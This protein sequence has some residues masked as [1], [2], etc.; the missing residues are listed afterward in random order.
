MGGAALPQ[1][2]G[3]SKDVGRPVIRLDI[4]QMATSIAAPA[5]GAVAGLL[6][7]AVLILLSGANPLV[8]YK[9]LALG[10]LGGP[11]QLTDTIL[12]ATPLLIMGLGLMVAFRCRAWNIGGAGQFYIGALC[13]VIVG[14]TF[15]NSW[16]AYLL[17]PAML[18]AGAAGGALWA[19]I[20][21]LLK[22]K[23]GINEII[24]TLM[25]NYIAEFLVLYLARGPMRETGSYLPQSAQL[26]GAARMPTLPASQLHMGILIGLLFIPATYV[27]LWRTPLGFRLRAIGSN[28]NAAKYAGMSVAAGIG[29]A[30]LFSG[31]LAGLTGIIQVSALFPRL[32]DGIAA[33]YGFTG[34]LVALLGRLSPAGVTIAA[35][36]FAALTIGAEAMQTSFGLPNSLAEVIQALVVLL[37]LAGDALARYR[38]K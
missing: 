14:L 26:V 9:T 38:R 29:S 11:R 24:T 6:L 12:E 8:A 19:G 10:A 31:A 4:S 28:Q 23:R 21:A 27:L 13:G 20:A 22:I 17:I 32:K 36:F 30:L 35:F 16:P 25:L 5:A 15:Q 2:A 37:V 3:P 34:I 33:D 7:G 1:D 18:V